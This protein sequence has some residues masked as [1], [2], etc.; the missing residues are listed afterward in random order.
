MDTIPCSWRS[1]V[2]VFP[3]ERDRDIHLVQYHD[4]MKETRT[5]SSTG[6]QKG[7]K[8]ERFDL[9]PTG[10]LA[11]LA[12]HYGLGAKKYAEHQWRNGYEWSKSYASIIRHLNAF[13]GGEDYDVCP[14]SQEGCSFVTHE[15]EP[16][17]DYVEGVTC[18]NHTGSHHLVAAAWHSF[19]LLEFKDTHPGHDDRFIRSQNASGPHPSTAS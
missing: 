10:P 7:V 11:E 3:T 9:I 13:W 19:T 1:C 12:R 16:F 18:Y 8:D 5:T 6:G 4:S 15:G 2:W 14:A 17:E